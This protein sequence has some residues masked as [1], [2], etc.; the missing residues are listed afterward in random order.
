MSCSMKSM[1][2]CIRAGI[3]ETCML[4]HLKFLICKIEGVVSLVS[5]FIRLKLVGV[6]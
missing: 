6:F 5:W 3:C 2:E 1:D 4:H